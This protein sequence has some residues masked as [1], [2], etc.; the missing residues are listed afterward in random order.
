MVSQAQVRNAD[1]ILK[2]IDAL[3]AL[4]GQINTASGANWTIVGPLYFHDA[5]GN[6]QTMD[7]SGLPSADF[8]NAMFQSANTLLN[9]LNAQ[10][11]AI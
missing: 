8:I 6:T 9:N 3:N 2:Q 4:L 10:L 1:P 11:T 7:I 5:S